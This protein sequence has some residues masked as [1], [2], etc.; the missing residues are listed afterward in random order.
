MVGE[1]KT[2]QIVAQRTR[3]KVYAG[4]PMETL[5]FDDKIKTVDDFFQGNAPVD[6]IQKTPVKWVVYGPYEKELI[7]TF[8]PLPDLELVYQNETVM[9]YKV[10][11]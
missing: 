11:H 6:W 2:S 5:F 8:A 3:L 9:I 1:I 10:K 4:H 7:P